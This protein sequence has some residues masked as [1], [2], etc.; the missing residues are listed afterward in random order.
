[1]IFG[2]TRE[3]VAQREMEYGLQGA[4]L[5]ATANAILITDRE[6]VVVWANP[7][8]EKLTGYTSDEI[9]GHT[10]RLWKSGVQDTA[11]Y[12]E[13]WQTILA[14]RIWHGELVNQRKD[15]SLYTEEMTITPVMD[16]FGVPAYFIAVKQDITE[17]K[18]YESALA[19]SERFL[20]ATLD[21]LSEH[22]AIVDE[23]GAILAVNAAWRSFAE[24]NG[25]NVA[26]VCEGQNYLQVCERATGQS[27]EGAEQFARA[28]RA[29]LAGEQELHEQEYPCHS[30]D[31]QRWF[32][33]RITRFPDAGPARAIISHE[34]IT[35][36]KLAEQAQQIANRRLQALN[37]VI[38]F[39]TSNREPMALLHRA[40]QEMARVFEVDR[41][42][43]VLIDPKTNVAVICNDDADPGNRAEWSEIL[44][45]SSP[46]YT[47]F[48][49]NPQTLVVEEAARSALLQPFRE[50]FAEWGVTSVMITPLYVRRKPAGGLVFA[51]SRAGV[52]GME[53]IA[54]AESAAQ[55][56]AQALE[57]RLLH[58]E[59]AAHNTRLA[60]LVGERTR[61]LAAL[62]RRTTTIVN[63]VSDAILLLGPDHGILAANKACELMLGYTES[64]LV[65]QPVNI[66]VEAHNAGRLLEAIESLNSG[67]DQRH[68]TVEA[69]CKDGTLLDADFALAYAANGQRHT[70]CSVRDISHFRAAERMRQQFISTVNHELRNPVAAISLLASSTARHYDRMTDD[71]RRQQI[72]QIQEQAKVLTDI[73]NGIL[74]ISRLD[75]RRQESGHAEVPMKAMLQSVALE[76]KPTVNSRRQVLRLHHDGR[77]HTL[78][79]EVVD[80]RIIWRNLLGNA[81]KYTPTGGAIDAYV[82]C[83]TKLEDGSIT[84]EPPL[85]AEGLAAP[86]TLPPGRYLVGQ[87]R[88]TGPGIPQE[89]RKQLF[90]RFVRGWAQNSSIPGTGLGLPL[91]R[92][93]LSAYGGD[94]AVHS[95]P[96]AGSTFSFWLPAGK[97]KDGC[98]TE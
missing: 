36:R 84:A 72:D 31:E 10:P 90:T 6:G 49:H 27:A 86:E 42:F 87:V 46:I 4:A 43:A 77:E 16:D 48:L 53:E 66:L 45:A 40:S 65:N 33:G 29:V 54:L 73:L 12:H 80:F 21:G 76:L 30:P 32:L 57:D 60:E 74:E 24:A 50:I 55:T 47:R 3:A 44:D 61:D 22:I 39:A 95:A 15:G 75:A 35:P 26:G 79:G 97:D 7:A 25:A 89:D 17:R 20:H 94:I 9:I 11:F 88:D 81:N 62:H 37:E 8:F 69:L 93:I 5:Q 67:M 14:G 18:R 96:R 83:A 70:V 52:F 68:L 59:I 2:I 63:N 98:G 23:T 71:Q 92:D 19:E 51:D 34:T 28:I 82:G 85:F 58:E 64:E 38:A 91:V 56:L 13:M 78:V 1:M 41:G